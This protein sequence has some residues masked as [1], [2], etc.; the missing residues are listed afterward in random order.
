M[1]CRQLTA[2]DTSYMAPAQY[3]MHTTVRCVKQLSKALLAM[4]PALCV[5]SYS[6]KSY[7]WDT[8]E[9]EV[10]AHSILC[11]LT[12]LVAVALP[13]GLSTAATI[14]VGNLLGANK[15]SHARLAGKAH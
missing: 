14:R 3:K 8:G 15:A 13:L 12:H 5:S 9:D 2:L 7:L 10:A 11:T 6:N 1:V 4:P